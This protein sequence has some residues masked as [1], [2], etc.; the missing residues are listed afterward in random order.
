MDTKWTE[1]C[2]ARLQNFPGKA[3]SQQGWAPPLGAVRCPM[4]ACGGVL[5]PYVVHSAIP[6][7]EPQRTQGIATWREVT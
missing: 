6:T 5:R 4:T 3:A 1:P 2:A 7:L